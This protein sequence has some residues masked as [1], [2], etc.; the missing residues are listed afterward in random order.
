MRK[1]VLISSFCDTQEKLDVL[2][3]NIN[4]IK[5]E[6]IDII[7]ISPFF[8]P[9]NVVESVTYFFKT[10][11]NP[12]LE[13]PLKSMYGWVD[14]VLNG[15]IHRMTRTYSDYGWASLTQVKQLSEI[16][17]LF[18]YEQFIHIIYD[19]KIEQNVLK[20]LHSEK[21][22]S[23]FPSKRN[24]YFWNA[25][26]HLM[27][28]DRLNLKKFISYITLD[29]YLSSL[30]S[31]AFIW[32]NDLHK[33]FP[34]NQELIPV[35]DEIFFYQNYDFFDYS[36]TKKF[37]MFIIKDYETKETI[38]FLF[39]NIK[40]TK[41]IKIKTNSNEYDFMMSNFSLFDTK[42]PYGKCDKVEILFDG[43]IYDISDKI[44]KIKHN[45]LRK[46]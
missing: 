9:V 37:S 42:I 23:I 5:N 46:C 4:I 25:G 10:N 26:L 39:S 7:L 36:P 43:E 30:S 6:N 20:E 21:T 24:E 28:F 34:Y 18:D 45:T 32:L 31:D 17:L 29:S 12:I 2:K 1:V 13:W 16:G 27:I 11:D 8:L 15:E 41:E 40:E 38:K 14:L 44:N 3:K 19:I 22:C 35:E 33:T